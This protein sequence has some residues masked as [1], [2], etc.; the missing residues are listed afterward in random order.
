MQAQ[1][2]AKTGE[3]AETPDGQKALVNEEGK[4][5]LV[6]EST[7]I[8]WDSFDRKTIGEVAQALAVASGRN[9]DEFAKPIQELA[10]ELQSVG[11]LAPV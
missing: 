3:L 1:K 4:A 6:Q 7:I 11:L 2:F 8:V 9:P 10:N 5:Y